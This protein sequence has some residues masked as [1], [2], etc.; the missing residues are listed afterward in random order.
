MIDH[1]SA[2]SIAITR[3]EAAR[4]ALAVGGASFAAFSQTPN[5]SRFSGVILGVQCYSFR[6]RPLDAAIQAMKDVGFGA[7]EMSY[8]HMEPKSLS[9]DREKLRQWRLTAPLE[10]FQKAGNQARAAGID[11]WAYCYNMKADLTD[12]ELERGFE[13]ARAMGSHTITASPN[14][15]TVKR[16]DAMAR[17]H[18]TRVALHNHSKIAPDELAAPDD[19]AAAIKGGSDYLGFTLD[20]GHFVAAGFDPLAFLRD[21]HERIWVVHVKDR[22]RNQ[23]ANVPF[24][25]GDT[26][27]KEVLRLIRDRKFDIKADI[28]YEYK[29]QDT[30]V[31]MRKCFEYCKDTLLS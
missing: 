8:L 5:R 14:L 24:G 13:M 25:E 7:C 29:G 11:P 17:K 2:K 21:H 22:K 16:I 23:G 27:I 18:K 19:F 12:A 6:D 3:R 10:E 15:S 30:L 4:L 31:E 9:K 28:E 1:K 20:I 26:P